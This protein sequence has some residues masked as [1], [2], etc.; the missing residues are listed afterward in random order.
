MWMDTPILPPL[1]SIRSPDD[2]VRLHRY[3]SVLKELICEAD[4]TWTVEFEN[5]IKSKHRQA[6]FDLLEMCYQ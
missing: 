1:N 2:T 3:A 4:D 6:L 5:N